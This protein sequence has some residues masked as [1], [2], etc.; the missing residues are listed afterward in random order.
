ML[1]GPRVY[2]RA[3]HARDFEAWR[4]VRLRNRGWV[5]PWEPRPDPGAANPVHDRDAFRARCGAWE[6]QRHFGTAHGFGMFLREG[7]FVGEVS[8]GNVQRGP[9]QSAYIGYWVDQEH[10]GRGLVPEGVALGLQYAFETLG[11]HRIEIAIV[12]RNQASRRVVEKLGLR[13]EGTARG[14]LQIGGIYEDHVRYGLTAEEWEARR[15][16][17]VTKFLT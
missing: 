6:R 1:V 3:L 15:A 16:D 13:E 2:L 17:L 8:I 11:L 10:A 12:P 7:P 9:F 4:N 14:F 5:D